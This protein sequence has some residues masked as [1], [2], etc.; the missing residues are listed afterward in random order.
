MLTKKS[1]NF[2][3]CLKFNML[4]PHWVLDILIPPTVFIISV[5]SNSILPVRRGK[6]LDLDL[7]L[8]NI[9]STPHPVYEQI[10]FIYLQNIPQ[11][12]LLPTPTTPTLT[13]TPTSSAW[14][15]TIA[16][17]L[18]PLTLDPPR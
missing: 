12:L 10:L 6:S 7:I 17:L 4:H 15:T 13:Q 8:D 18:S 5:N 2:E 11:I 9:L 3:K 16:S 14:L 1:N